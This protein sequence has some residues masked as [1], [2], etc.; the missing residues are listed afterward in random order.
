MA[1]SARAAQPSRQAS[2]LLVRAVADAPAEAAGGRVY[3]SKGGASK[4]AAPSETRAAKPKR[5]VVVEEA[6]IVVGKSFK[7]TVVRYLVR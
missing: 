4:V 5:V 7:G 6:D 2:R 1:R 3:T